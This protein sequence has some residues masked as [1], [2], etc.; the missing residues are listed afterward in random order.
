MFEPVPKTKGFTLLELLI[1][2]AIIGLLAAVALGAY[3]GYVNNAHAAKMIQHYNDS[4]NLVG[5]MF[6]N[7]DA[8]RAVGVS[9]SFPATAAD[10]ISEINPGNSMAPGGGAAFVVGTGNALTGA[11]GVQYTGSFATRDAQVVLHRPAYSG[12]TAISTTI[13]L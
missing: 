2:V 7:A 10:W 1:V 4:K 6:I 11:V 5:S 8:E 13:S 3:Q 12:V 9:V